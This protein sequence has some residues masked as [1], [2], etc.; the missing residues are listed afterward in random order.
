[1]LLHVL[2]HCRHFQRVFQSIP[3]Y[4]YVPSHRYHMSTELHIIWT[5]LQTFHFFCCGRTMNR[6]CLHFK[7]LFLTIHVSRVYCTQ[8]AQQTQESTST[9]FVPGLWDHK[10]TFPPCYQAVVSDSLLRC[11]LAQKEAQQWQ[12]TTSVG[13]RP[14]RVFPRD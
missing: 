3:C 5:E 12:V 4:R 11:A 7:T 14:E 9:D 2:S 13:C 1:M 8:S 6:S 10:S